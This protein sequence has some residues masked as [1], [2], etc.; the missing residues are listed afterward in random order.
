MVVIPKEGIT[1]TIVGMTAIDPATAIED[2]AALWCPYC[3]SRLVRVF[4]WCD[5]CAA[6]RF[7]LRE[8]YCIEHDL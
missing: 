7:V 5:E 8:L 4:G 3:G 6:D 2:D 1:D